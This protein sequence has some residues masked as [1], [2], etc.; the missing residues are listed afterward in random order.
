MQAGQDDTGMMTM[1]QSLVMH[2]KSGSLTKADAI[3]HSS[4]PEELSKLLM[5]VK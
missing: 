1:N 4:L 5:N 2:V 3:E